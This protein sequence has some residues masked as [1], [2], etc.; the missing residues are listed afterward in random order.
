M[1]KQL[2]NTNSKKFAYRTLSM[3]TTDFI[4]PK[5][6]NYNYTIDSSIALVKKI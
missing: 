6:S 1:S 3:M 2:K 4:F 5:I